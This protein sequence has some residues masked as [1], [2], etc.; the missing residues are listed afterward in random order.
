MSDRI[1]VAVL[2]GG[3]SAEHEISIVSA[4]AICRNLGPDRF[5]VIPIYITR[6]GLWK[7]APAPP[8]D[9][10][11]L[12]KGKALSFLPWG[13][14]KRPLPI[15]ADVY[16]PVLH[17]RF[18]E[19]GTIQGLL[20]MAD[21]PYVGSGVAASALGMDKV[22]AKELW[23]AKGIPVV[24][25]IALREVDFRTDPAGHL[26]R[27]KRRFRTPFFVKPSRLGSSVGI[28]KVKDHADTAA[29]MDK[30]FS[31]D[32]LVL[33]EDG[34]NGREIECSVLGNDTPRASVPGEVIPYRDFYDYNDKYIDG[35][36]T[37]IV[38]AA[39]PA[40]TV[41]RIR[42]LAV[43]AYEVLDCAGFARVD[44]FLEKGASTVYVNEINT[45]PGFTEISMYPKL[46]E[47]SGLPFPRL[48]EQ[49]VELGLE[50]HRA[51]KTRIDRG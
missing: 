18:G 17:G 25:Y 1:R 40:K 24:P 3:R 34:I 11:S 38:P 43:R 22:L 49:L 39:A 41:E 20:E 42:G 13:P 4:S 47:A 36:T 2:F 51:R 12:R 7:K 31:Y 16:F 23:E 15:E 14:G 44:F 28:S 50:R 29:A 32:S 8:F 46:W 48:V 33:V 45:I 37:F 21:V 30:A 5:E 26:R 19:D 6:E 10:R 27:L 35:K 9:E